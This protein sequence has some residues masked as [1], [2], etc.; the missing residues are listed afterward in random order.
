M[1]FFSNYYV[2]ALIWTGEMTTHLKVFHCHPAIFASGF[3]FIF[4]LF[5]TVS[6]ETAIKDIGVMP[7]FAQTQLLEQSVNNMF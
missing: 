1:F 6:I 7:I 5:I 4:P 2:P 3:V